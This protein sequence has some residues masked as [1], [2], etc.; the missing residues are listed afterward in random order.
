M[1]EKLVAGRGPF[2]G[3]KLRKLLFSEISVGVSYCIGYKTS[4]SGHTCSKQRL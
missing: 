1:Y 4:G 2:L 3:I